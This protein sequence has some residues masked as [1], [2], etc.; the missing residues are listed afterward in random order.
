MN[1]YREVA[2]LALSRRRPRN[3]LNDVVSALDERLIK[4]PEHL[5]II[6]RMMN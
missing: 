6:R 2:V 3:E 5:E 1:D 4:V